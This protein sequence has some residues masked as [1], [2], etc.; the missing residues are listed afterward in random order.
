MSLFAIR[1]DKTIQACRNAIDQLEN[2][3]KEIKEASIDAAMNRRWFKPK[4]REKAWEKIRNSWYRSRISWCISPPWL[5]GD[6][7]MERAERLL[8]AC[9]MA[10]GEFVQLDTK[11]V[12]MVKEWSEK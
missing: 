7:T 9:K 6:S 2:E 8:S 3:R 5:F 11:D 1:K 10:E 12:E 4:T